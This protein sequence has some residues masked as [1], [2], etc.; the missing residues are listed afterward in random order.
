MGKFSLSNSRALAIAATFGLMGL[1][2]LLSLAVRFLPV[3]E[4]GATLRY[5]GWCCLMAGGGAL[6]L[7]LFTKNV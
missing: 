6:V 2:V 7:W 4:Y 3:G 5:V 1:G